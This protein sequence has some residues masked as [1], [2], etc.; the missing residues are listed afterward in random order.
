MLIR[1]ALNHLPG[2]AALCN[3]YVKKSHDQTDS[4]GRYL[5]CRFVNYVIYLMYEEPES[6]VRYRKYTPKQVN[7]KFTFHG[8]A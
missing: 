4:T 6:S 5:S 8:M 7:P 1:E 3:L 2:K